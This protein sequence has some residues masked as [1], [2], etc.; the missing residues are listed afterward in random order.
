MR[1]GCESFISFDYGFDMLAALWISVSH[2]GSLT[3]YRELCVPGLTLSA[4]A[5]AIVDATRERCSF[6]VASPDLWNRRQDSGLS[7]VEIMSS[8]P[9]LPPLRRADDR[10]IPGWNALREYLSPSE[11]RPG[12]TISS[13]CTELIRCMSALLYSK[14]GGEDAAS[15]PHSITHAPEALRYG[16]MQKIALPSER[17]NGFRFKKREK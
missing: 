10:R 9:G 8:V 6:C 7:G 17:D 15:E 16:V 4:A 11:G 13:S 14:D 2:D 12:L 1:S 3:V 5:R